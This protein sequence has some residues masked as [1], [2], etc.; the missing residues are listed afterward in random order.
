MRHDEGLPPRPYI[1]RT[2]ICAASMLGACGLLTHVAWSA[3]DADVGL[4]GVAIQTC[5]LF[6]AGGLVVGSLC[7]AITRFRVSSTQREHSLY[8]NALMVLTCLCAGC[9]L[10]GCFSGAWVAYMDGQ[11]RELEG[12]P[13]SSCTI[14]VSSDPS[15][16]TTG[17]G[18]G[19]YGNA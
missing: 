6:A 11:I 1:P 15:L 7:F 17:Y 16:T 3:Y 14:E 5:V 10:G 2:M 12:L 19:H 13:L 9:F 8:F 4:G 18:A